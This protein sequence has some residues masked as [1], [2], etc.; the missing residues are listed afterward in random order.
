MDFIILTVFIFL[1]R[2][3]EDLKKLS[4]VKTQTRKENNEDARRVIWAVAKGE[5]SSTRKWYGTC[6]NYRGGSR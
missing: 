5:E 3:R 6:T 4:K 1:N 2:R